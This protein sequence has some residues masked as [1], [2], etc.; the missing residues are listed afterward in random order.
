M[1]KLTKKNTNKIN[2]KGNGLYNNKDK[3][4]DEYNTSFSQLRYT[5]D[6]YKK[7]KEVEQKKREIKERNEQLKKIYQVFFLTC[8]PKLMLYIK[9][10]KQD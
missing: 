6:E 9:C 7:M 3:L 2:H 4:R 1:T 10:V 8:I 5:F